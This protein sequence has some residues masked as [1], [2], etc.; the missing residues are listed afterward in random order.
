METRTCS[1]KTCKHINPQPIENYGIKTRLPSG[2]AYECRECVNA[3]HANRRN[4]NREKLRA[5]E[6]KRYSKDRKKYCL[7]SRACR[8]KQ[9]YWPTLTAKQ[10]ENEWNKLYAVQDGVCSIC[11]RTKPLEVE[12]CHKTGKVRSL[13]CGGCNTAVARV[14]ENFDIAIA[15]AKY[16]LG[17][18]NV[19]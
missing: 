10:A 6:R 9:K 2:R 11:K 19:I 18:H 15:V 12:H 1:R 4:E 17:Y 7:K 16:I 5:Q 8:F 13:A 3:Y 14:E